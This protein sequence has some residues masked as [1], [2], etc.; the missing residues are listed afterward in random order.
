MKG[1]NKGALYLLSVIF[2]KPL[3]DPGYYERGS[4]PKLL[5][6]GALLHNPATGCKW[7]LGQDSLN[8]LGDH[9]AAPLYHVL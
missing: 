2:F 8:L 3:Q 7:P 5:W 4:Y 6:S 1:L 9:Q